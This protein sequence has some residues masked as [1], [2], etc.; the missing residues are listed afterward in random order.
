MKL[1]SNVQYLKGVGPRRATALESVGIRSVYDLLNYLPRRY[2][3]RSMIVPIG[4]LK[5]NM[6]ATITLR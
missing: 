2:L 5:A 3:D 6:E 4:S 1:D